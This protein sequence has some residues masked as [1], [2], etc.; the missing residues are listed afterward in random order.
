MGVTLEAHFKLKLVEN[1]LNHLFIIVF[2]VLVVLSQTNK[3]HI[4]GWSLDTTV[5]MRM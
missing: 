2:S 5:Y 4:I 3:S 1:N